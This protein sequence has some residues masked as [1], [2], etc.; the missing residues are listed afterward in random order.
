MNTICL[1]I[2]IVA[3]VSPLNLPGNWILQ[4]KGDPGLC[5]VHRGYL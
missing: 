2:R 1:S 5:T 3:K 4:S